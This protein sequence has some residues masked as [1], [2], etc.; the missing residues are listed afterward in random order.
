MAVHI[1]C[2]ECYKAG[3]TS[4]GVFP[5]HA[6]HVY[7]SRCP[8]GHS[9]I[10]CLEN[11]DYDI[12]YELACNALVDGYPREAAT[13]FASSLESFY[14]FAVGAILRNAGRSAEI[15]E[16]P[17]SRSEPQIGAYMATWSLTYN[18]KA[19][20]LSG[21]RV[22]FR[23]NVVHN[24]HIPSHDEAVKFGRDVLEII[25]HGLQVLGR[26]PSRDFDELRAENT[27][28]QVALA[29]QYVGSTRAYLT[30]MTLINSR[31]EA[32][33]TEDLL[34]RYLQGLKERRGIVRGKFGGESS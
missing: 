23:N 26:P 17:L 28:K 4:T 10:L 31:G 8:S 32:E 6:D 16:G 15:F 21:A 7:H 18:T 13:T 34:R 9:T 2:Y 14:K 30:T 11:P 22:N 27:K 33:V 29:E 24:G 25:S 12:L 1:P 20:V 3:V 19:K 5:F